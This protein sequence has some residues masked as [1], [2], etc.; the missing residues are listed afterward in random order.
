[1]SPDPPALKATTRL[2]GLVAV[3]LWAL[4]EAFSAR[5][6]HA[7]APL[8]LTISSFRLVGEVMRSPG[9]IRP[10]ELAR[11]LGVRPPTVSSAV[12]RL[13]ARGIVRRVDDPDDPRAY[14]VCLTPGAPL[15]PGVEVLE[16]IDADLVQGLPESD[17]AELLRVLDLLSSR[18]SAPS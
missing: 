5:L 12:A 10:G 2:D 17:R 4:A 3:R 1:M 8:D 16:S 14:R 15:Q 6:S 13:E 18:L 11:R 7:L 9:G